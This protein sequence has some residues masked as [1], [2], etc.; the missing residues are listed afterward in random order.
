MGVE[1]ELRRT[2]SGIISIDNPTAHNCWTLRAEA[3]LSY[4]ASAHGNVVPWYLGAADRIAAPGRTEIQ[5]AAPFL[6]EVITTLQALEAVV[7]IE[8]EAQAGRAAYQERCA[9][10]VHTLPTRHAG[11]RVFASRP[12]A[13]RRSWRLFSRLRGRSVPRDVRPGQCGRC[14]VPARSSELPTV[15]VCFSDS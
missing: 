8:H 12:T 10:Q 1:A 6:H 13:R 4:R 11:P 15:L 5:R 9:P 14:P 2:D 7:L 3:D